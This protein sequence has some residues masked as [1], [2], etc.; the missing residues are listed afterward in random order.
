MY[1]WD[2]RSQTNLAEGIKRS[3]M[4]WKDGMRGG[5]KLVSCRSTQLS[6]ESYHLSLSS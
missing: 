5:E 6:D 1:Y 4:G 2:E 3:L